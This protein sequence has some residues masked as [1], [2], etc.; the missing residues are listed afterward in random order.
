MFN[1]LN[2]SLLT[3]SLKVIHVLEQYYSRHFPPQ[4]GRTVLYLYGY[5]NQQIDG[6]S[7]P[8][9]VTEPD[10]EKVAAVTLEV[11]TLRTEV[12]MLIKVRICSWAALLFSC[13]L[14]KSLTVFHFLCLCLCRAPI[15]TQKTSK[16][17]SHSSSSRSVPTFPADLYSDLN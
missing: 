4:G 6:L 1:L 3:G 14:C 12:D 10:K 5:T 8:D 11:M 16:I 2:E 13:I 9:D 7:F 17:S 15:L